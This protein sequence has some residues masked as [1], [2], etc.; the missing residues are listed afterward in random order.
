MSHDAPQATPAQQIADLNARFPVASKV[1][2]P[3]A[4]APLL[5]AGALYLDNGPVLI[6]RGPEQGSLIF[7]SATDLSP[8]EGTGS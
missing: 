2:P 5:V 8:D 4:D 7:I 3:G 6:V 1:T